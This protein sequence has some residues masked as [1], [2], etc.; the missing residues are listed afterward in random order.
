MPERFRF[1]KDHQIDRSRIAN[2]VRTAAADISDKFDINPINRKEIL[3]LIEEA[4]KGRIEGWKKSKEGIVKSDVIQAV[5]PLAEDVLNNI[6]K[7]EEKDENFRVNLVN[8]KVDVTDKAA[9]Q[10][11]DKEK[12]KIFG[13]IIA[14]TLLGYIQGEAI[15]VGSEQEEIIFAS[16][17]EALQYLSDLTGEKIVIE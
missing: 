4:V 1:A 6:K 5:N 9:M 8:Q 16:E 14:E 15:K 11:I 7:K 12:V 17:T 3:K 10:K 2:L 13:K